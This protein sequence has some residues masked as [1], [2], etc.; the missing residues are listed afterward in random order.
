MDL[1]KQLLNAAKA[2]QAAKVDYTM[3]LSKK[4][5]LRQEYLAVREQFLNECLTDD[6]HPEVTI[7]E[8]VRAELVCEEVTLLVFTGPKNL[9][10]SH[11][12]GTI[13]IHTN[14]RV[15]YD[16]KMHNCISIFA[17]SDGI[18]YRHLLKSE[19]NGDIAYMDIVGKIREDSVTSPSL[20]EAVMIVHLSR[21]VLG[22]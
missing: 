14:A 2:D 13:E 11:H 19:T 16:D 17:L 22:A 5:R 1:L 9:N 7:L 12:K 18:F 21:G 15:K 10:L 4:H 3:A 20:E 8:G 6:D